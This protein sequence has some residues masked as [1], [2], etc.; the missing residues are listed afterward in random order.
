MYVVSQNNA[1]LLN[2]NVV[3]STRSRWNKK[4]KDLPFFPAKKPMIL[5]YVC[6]TADKLINRL[7]NGADATH[8]YELVDVQLHM[9]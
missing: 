2:Y 7:K 5:N 9:R 4:K 6:F 3:S 8:T 1:I